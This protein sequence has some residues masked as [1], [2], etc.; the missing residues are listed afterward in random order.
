M[1][2]TIDGKK[3]RLTAAQARVL[4]WMT[5]G[6]IIHVYVNPLQYELIGPHVWPGYV[7]EVT[8][9]ELL[10]KGIITRVMDMRYC[11][12]PL[13]RRVAEKLKEKK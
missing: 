13:G 6:C 11:L 8:I 10:R 7:A 1:I 3:I 9:K 12:M 2:V 5:Q 4:Y